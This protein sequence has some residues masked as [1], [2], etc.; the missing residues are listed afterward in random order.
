M[1]LELKDKVIFVTGGGAGIGE[2]ISTACMDEGAKVVVVSRRSANVQSFLD[3]MA[4][5]RRACGFFEADLQ[6]A[7]LCRKVVNYVE[8]VHGRI[9][10]LVNNAGANDGIGL[11]DGD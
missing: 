6:D 3:R 2:A 10:G 7:S 9:D 5:E 11:A 8:Q 1:D 4:S